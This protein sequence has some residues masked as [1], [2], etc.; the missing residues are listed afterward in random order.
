MTDIRA[1]TIRGF[2]AAYGV[3]RSTAFRLL[4]TGKLRGVRMG[5][6]STLILEESAREWLAGLPAQSPAHTQASDGVERTRTN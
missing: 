4:A 6:R 1:R 5:P 3:S 2:C